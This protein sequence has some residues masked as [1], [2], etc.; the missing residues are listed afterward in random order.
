[1]MIMMTVTSLFCFN[2]RKHVFMSFTNLRLLMNSILFMVNVKLLAN[3]PL[4]EH[5]SKT[6]WTVKISVV[7]VHQK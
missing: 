3:L 2:S 1:M 5:N 4:F 6:K 7:W